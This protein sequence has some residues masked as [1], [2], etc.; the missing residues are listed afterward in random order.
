MNLL[1]LGKQGQSSPRRAR[2]PLKSVACM[3][4]KGGECFADG[5]GLVAG[6]DSA[7]EK[8]TIEK[9]EGGCERICSKHREW[10]GEPRFEEGV[11][12]GRI[13]GIGKGSCS[14]CSGSVCPHQSRLC[15]FVGSLSKAY[16][17]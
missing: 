13:A 1:K 15:R 4:V 9:A 3:G 12:L 5:Q 8:G 17:A 2:F 6:S 7:M 10:K 14:L 11:V 16:A